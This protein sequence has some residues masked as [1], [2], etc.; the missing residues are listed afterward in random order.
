MVSKIVTGGS[1][2][3]SILIETIANPN[4]DLVYRAAMGDIFG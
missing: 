3:Q 2:I 1:V 4:G